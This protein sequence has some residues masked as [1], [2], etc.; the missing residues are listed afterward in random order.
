MS[1]RLFLFT[2][3]AVLVA[4]AAHV[5]FGS[6]LAV[7]ANEDIETV[8]MR[9]TYEDG[10]H[11]ISGMVMVP[12][13]CHDLNV[14]TKDLDADTLLLIFETWEQPYRT[15]TGESHEPRAFRVVAFA[16]ED[17]GF[18]AIFDNEWRPVRRVTDSE[19]VQP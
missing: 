7:S 4:F 18:R 2:I 3:S 10:A 19:D 6:T 14:R 11:H 1:A 16:P 17:V 8:V 12:S 13:D 5:F 9:S 15:C